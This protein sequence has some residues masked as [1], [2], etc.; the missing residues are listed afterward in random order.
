MSVEVE[1]VLADVDTDCCNGFK[2]DGL[3]WH[4]MPLV[5]ASP[6]PPLR[7]GGA[8]ARRVHPINGRLEKRTCLVRAQNVADDHFWTYQ[9]PETLNVS[10]VNLGCR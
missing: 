9:H 2:A 4:G 8:G 5:F 10:A 6:V 7:L 1:R 3:A